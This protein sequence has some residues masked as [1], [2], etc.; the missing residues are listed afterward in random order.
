MK[1]IA[2]KN[3]YVRKLTVPILLISA[4]KWWISTADLNRQQF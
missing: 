3:V 2:N 1:Q 4:G